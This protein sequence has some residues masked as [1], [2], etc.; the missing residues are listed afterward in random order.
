MRAIKRHV[1]EVWRKK[2]GLH[3]LSR[4]RERLARG[5]E[6]DTCASAPFILISSNISDQGSGSG[7]LRMRVSSRHPS[8][9][10]VSVLD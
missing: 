9:R 8:K 7:N 10:P 3:S 4:E 6:P 2:G 5:G 1:S